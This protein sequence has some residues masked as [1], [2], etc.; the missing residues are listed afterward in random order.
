MDSIIPFGHGYTLQFMKHDEGIHI[1]KHDMNREVWNMLMLFP[2]DSWNT[3]AIAKAVAG[4]SLLR[5][6][7]DSTNNARVVCKVHLHDEAMIPDEW[8]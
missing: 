2:N 3:C 7:Y 4:F 6:W 1:R 5:Y 8:W